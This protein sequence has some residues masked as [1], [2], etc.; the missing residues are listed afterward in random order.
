M[1][2]GRCFDIIFL[3]VNVP[4][5][6]KLGDMKDRFYEELEHVFRYL[7]FFFSGSSNTFR[8]LA[9]NLVL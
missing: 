2:R 1:V 5:V 7:S 6:D 3:N 9:R 8:A 4:T